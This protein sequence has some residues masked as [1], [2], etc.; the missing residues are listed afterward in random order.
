MVFDYSIHGLFPNTVLA[1]LGSGY[2]D[3]TI[4]TLDRYTART[5]LNFVQTQQPYP[6]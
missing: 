6:P 1:A 4:V 3:K 2:F 5:P